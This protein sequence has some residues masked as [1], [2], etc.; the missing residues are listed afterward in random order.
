MFPKDLCMKTYRI[1]GRANIIW[2]FRNLGDYI[3]CMCVHSVSYVCN[4]DLMCGYS[5]AN[6]L[7]WLSELM[8]EYGWMCLG[9]VVGRG[10][11]CS[12]C[13]DRS[14]AISATISSFT[15]VNQAFLAVTTGEW[16]W[17]R[18][19]WWF[20]WFC[21]GTSIVILSLLWTVTWQQLVVLHIPKVDKDKSNPSIYRPVALTG[22]ICKGV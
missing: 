10:E 20:H 12:E 1:V 15:V 13:T 17:R 11:Q 14:V 21:A 2:M 9:D 8:K 16:C 3:S 6:P 18:V 5:V 22:Y 19:G 7:V 4:I